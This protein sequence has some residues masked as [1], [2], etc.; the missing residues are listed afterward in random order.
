MPQLCSQ[1]SRANPPEASYCYYDGALLAGH[2]AN[3]AAHQGTRPF[4]HQFVFPSGLTCR[5]FDQLAMACQQNWRQAL[6]VL[7]QGFLAGFF[8]GLGRADLAQAAQEALRFPDADRGLDRLLSK[9]PTQV[10]E[11]P[12]LKA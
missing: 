5:N 12:K 9:L 4:P 6:D 7:K 10:L 11:P 2:S 3:G 8:G 1:C